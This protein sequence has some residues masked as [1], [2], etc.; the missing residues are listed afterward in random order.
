MYSNSNNTKTQ[1]QTQLQTL[2]LHIPP[3]LHLSAGIRPSH[4]S[5]RI[6][7]SASGGRRNENHTS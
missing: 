1:T 2:M 6:R 3:P 4:T 7:D 5:P